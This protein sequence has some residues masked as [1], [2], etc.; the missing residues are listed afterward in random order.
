[1]LDL[2][3][4]PEATIRAPVDIDLLGFYLLT[5]K[6]IIAFGRGDDLLADRLENQLVV[7]ERTPDRADLLATVRSV[8]P[9]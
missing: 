7:L 8:I 5:G 4:S 2:S 1:V 3:F 6:P 9:A